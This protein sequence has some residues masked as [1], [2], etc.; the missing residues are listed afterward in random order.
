MALEL[1]RLT[2]NGHAIAAQYA[3]HEIATL[4]EKEFEA[5]LGHVNL[6]TT[7]KYLHVATANLQVTHEKFHPHGG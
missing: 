2:D 4:I 7:A 1:C 3:W 5:L 6:A